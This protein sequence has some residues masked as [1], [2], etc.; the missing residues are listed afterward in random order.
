[1]ADVVVAARSAVVVGLVVDVLALP[2]HIAAIVKILRVLRIT[3]GCGLGT[4]V[5]GAGMSHVAFDVAV[6]C[7]DVLSHP[8]RHDLRLLILI[9]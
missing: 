2:A 7:Y 8:V 9:I 3:V 6:G 5:D 4:I 1:M